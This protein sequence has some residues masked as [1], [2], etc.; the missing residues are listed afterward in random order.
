MT[1]VKDIYAVIGG[2]HLTGKIFEPIIS[3][4][5]KALK[6]IKPKVIVPQHCTGWRATFEI[7]RDFSE[8]FVPNSVGTKFTL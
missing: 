2:F 5:I 1:G 7:T 4:T 3:P 8:A 6:E